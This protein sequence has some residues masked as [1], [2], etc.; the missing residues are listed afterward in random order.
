MDVIERKLRE[1]IQEYGWHV[2]NVVPEDSHP[3]HSYSVGLFATFDH[4]EIVIVGLPGPTAQRL[5]NNLADE[6]KEGATYEPGCKYDNILS[7]YA[8]MFVRVAPETYRE[9]FGRA[10]DYYGSVSFSVVQMAWPDRNHFF[11]WEPSCA[12]DIR[13]LQPILAR[14]QR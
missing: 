10:L 1:D 8:V 7:G 11:P 9:H 4:P 3:P 13:K 12:A 2:V 14:P 6:I 5:I